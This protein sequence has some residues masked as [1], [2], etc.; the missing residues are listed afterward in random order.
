VS[1]SSRRRNKSQKSDAME[2]QPPSEVGANPAGH[3]VVSHTQVSVSQTSSPIPLPEILAD[4]NTIVAPD[5][6]D[7]ILQMAEEQSK[8]RRS[9]EKLVIENDVKRSWYGLGAG[10]VVAMTALLGGVYATVNGYPGAGGTIA[11]ASVVALVSVFV[12]GTSS[13]RSERAERADKLAK[14]RD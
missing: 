2:R 6:A 4:Y 1:K 9:L 10:F 14:R 8:H 5:A 13:R 7:R 11:T 3:G 12:I